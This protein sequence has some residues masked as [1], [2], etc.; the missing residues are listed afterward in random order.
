MLIK[1]KS[2]K[3][4]NQLKIKGSLTIN[5]SKQS[6]IILSIHTI[7]I[8]NQDDVETMMNMVEPGEYFLD[9]EFPPTNESLYTFSNSSDGEDD[10]IEW[11][12]PQVMFVLKRCQKTF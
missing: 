7:C 5:N 2:R 1:I 3:N 10:Q 4:K 6:K 9:T 11:K 12:R 8:K